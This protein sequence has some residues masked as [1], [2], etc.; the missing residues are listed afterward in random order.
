MMWAA[1][2]WSGLCLERQLCDV[3]SK[4]MEQC[5]LGQTAGCC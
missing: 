1:E 4:D 2:L 3:D 5:L